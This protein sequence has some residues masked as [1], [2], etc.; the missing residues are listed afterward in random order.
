MGK[1]VVCFGL[2]RCRIIRKWVRLWRHLHWC[3]ILHLLDVVDVVW[4]LALSRFLDFHLCLL[5][6]ADN[7]VCYSL[8]RFVISSQFDHEFLSLDAENF[9][10][11]RDAFYGSCAVSVV[12]HVFLADHLARADLRQS[13]GLI[14]LFVLTN[15]LRLTEL[16]PLLLD[17]LEWFLG[18]D[19]TPVFV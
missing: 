10:V 5:I 15:F 6:L 13:N 11:G 16:T 2:S 12:K 1:L 7:S 9:G 4:M 3:F 8:P 18:T 19:V 14:S 17:F